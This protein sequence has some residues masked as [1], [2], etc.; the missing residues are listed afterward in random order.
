MKKLSI[1]I[2]VYNEERTLPLI[3][4]KIE[5]VNIGM[6]KEIIFVDDGSKDGSRNLLNQFAKAGHKVIFQSKNQGK[7][8]AIR[9]GFEVASGDIVLVQDADLEYN[10]NEYPVLL[11]PI[12]DGDADVV[13]GSRFITPFPRRV[14]YY[15][16]YLANKLVTFLS[17]LFTGLNLSD[18][19]TGYK[20]FTKK[21]I[22]EILPCLKSKRFG[23][24]PELTAQISKHKFKIYEVGISYRGRT[25]G[26]GKKIGW[27]DGLAAIWHIIRFNL[28]TRK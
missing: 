20:V 27:K 6:E 19:E 28:F 23:I 10:P 18:M 12:L 4:P 8:A 3:L 1:V 24:E 25:Y 13:Y 2:P 16:H 21:A 7:G 5:S 15:N 22:K 26:E 9:K 17:N 14:L 11:Q